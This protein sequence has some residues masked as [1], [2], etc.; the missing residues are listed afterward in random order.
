MSRTRN[1]L[2]NR[3]GTLRSHVAGTEH[4]ITRLQKQLAAERDELAEVEAALAAVDALTEPPMPTPDEDDEL[5]AEI[6]AAE[7]AEEEETDRG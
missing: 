1:Y 2:S 6:D 4:E 3:V 5:A 7:D